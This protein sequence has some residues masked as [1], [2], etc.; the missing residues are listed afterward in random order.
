MCILLGS[1][2]FHHCS[3][4]HRGEDS[5]R[6]A[7][8]PIDSMCCHLDTL[9]CRQGTKHCLPWYFSLWLVS[10]VT[11]VCFHCHGCKFHL[12]HYTCIHLDSS[13]LC[14]CSKQLL[15]EDNNPTHQRQA[16]SMYSHRGTQSH[17]RGKQ[18]FPQPSLSW[19]LTAY[20]SVLFVIAIPWKLSSEF[21]V[22]IYSGPLILSWV[23][24][25]IGPECCGIQMSTSYYQGSTQILVDSSEYHQSNTRLLARGNNDRVHH[26]YSKCTCK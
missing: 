6:T 10:S 9:M 13:V 3:K 24:L 17:H 15:E 22:E 16:C 20:V 25:W 18:H 2:A 21:A 7:L 1:N 5:N 26:L 11:W 19:Q 8:R 4:L 12:Q 14:H 23:V